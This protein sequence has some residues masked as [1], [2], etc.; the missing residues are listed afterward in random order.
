[1]WRTLCSNPNSQTQKNPETAFHKRQFR[2][3][4]QFRPITRKQVKNVT[5]YLAIWRYNNLVFTQIFLAIRYLNN[6]KLV[7]V[8]FCGR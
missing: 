4:S 1:V 5:I 7:A 8:R 6:K 3:F 2:D